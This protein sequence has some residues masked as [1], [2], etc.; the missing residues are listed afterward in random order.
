MSKEEEKNSDNLNESEENSPEQTETNDFLSNKRERV[1]EK[2]KNENNFDI[3]IL[4][5]ENNNLKIKILKDDLICF[6]F[7]SQYLVLGTCLTSPNP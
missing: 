5:E 1:D 2:D 6:S 4:H 3:H 7:I